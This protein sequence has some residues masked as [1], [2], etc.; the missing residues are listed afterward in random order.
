MMVRRII[1]IVLLICGLGLI[2]I[3][4]YVKQ[5]VDQGKMQI[6]DAQKKVDTTEDWL[7]RS[8]YTRDI[9]K[10]IAGSS[11][12]KINAAHGEVAEYEKM[13]GWAQIGGI[14]LVII[15]TGMTFLGRRKK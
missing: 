6:S 9:G 2:G 13:A 5:Q 15:G 7:S 14:V 3:S 4:M 1:G 8:P 12:K 10:G 11:Q